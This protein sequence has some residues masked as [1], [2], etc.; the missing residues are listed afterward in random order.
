MASGTKIDE[1]ANILAGRIL[2]GDYEA[3][4]RLPAEVNLAE[5]LHVSRQTIRSALQRLQS[6]NLIDIVPSSG[7][8][9]RFPRVKVTIGP[10]VPVHLQQKGVAGLY[11][12]LEEQIK[13][14]HIRFLEP[15]SVAQAKGAPGIKMNLKVGTELLRRYRLCHMN[16]M[17]YC[18]VDS[19]YLADLLPPEV[20]NNPD[21]ARQ[22]DSPLRWLSE[23][24]EP[25][26][27]DAY[28]RFLC[29]MPDGKEAELLNINRTQPIVQLER[30]VFISDGRVFEYTVVIANAALYEFTYTYDTANWDD[31]TK[32]IRVG[33]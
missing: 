16:Q 5:E 21:V 15:P 31:L 12:A 24:A 10:L 23:Y 26:P 6:D 17:P 19:Y 11:R 25:T 27:P 2:E 9:V 14:T 7:A 1:V 4:E 28:E 18:I 8:Y 22:A 3:G 30:W 13:E 32:Q 29:R 33:L 20:L